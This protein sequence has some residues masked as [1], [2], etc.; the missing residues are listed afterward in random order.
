MP[1]EEKNKTTIITETLKY[2]SEKPIRASLEVKTRPEFS[3]SETNARDVTLKLAMQLCL[4]GND[5]FVLQLLNE[6]NK[7]NALFDFFEKLSKELAEKAEKATTEAEQAIIAAQENE[8]Q[9]LKKGVNTCGR[10]CCARVVL[11]HL[12]L[13]EFKN[14]FKNRGIDSDY[15]VTI[16]T[17]YLENF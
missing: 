2:V 14:L 4:M 1:N 8:L 15:L 9:K 3:F 10:W 7:V 12:P 13:E 5:A 16:F 6:K 17:E 11:K